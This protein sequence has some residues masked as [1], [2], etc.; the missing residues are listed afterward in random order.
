MFTTLKPKFLDSGRVE[1]FCRC[2]KDKMTGYL[3]SLAKEDKNDLL[4]NDPFPVIIR[5]HH[6]NSAYQFNKAD[7]MTLAD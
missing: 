3:R 2:S 5:C 6:C 4:E 7:L 1:F